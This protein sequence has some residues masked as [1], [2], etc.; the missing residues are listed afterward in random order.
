MSR[1]WIR[2]Q[3]GVL[4]FL[5]AVVTMELWNL[6][7]ARRPVRGRSGCPDI[8][9]SVLVP[10]R[11]EESRIG[12]CMDSLLSQDYP[13][14]EV[15]VLDDESE[16]R[17]LDAARRVAARDDRARAI[18]GGPL[19]EG[20]VGKNWA[21]DQ[22]SRLAGGRLLLFTD[23]DTLHRPDAV[24]TA[25]SELVVNRLGMLTGLPRQV[26]LSP[27]EKL[28]VPMLG[29][30]L[31]C[32]LPLGIAHRSGSPPLGAAVG[33]FMLF[34]REAYAATGGHAGCRD[35]IAE[36]F[37]LARASV[38][39]GLSWRFFDLGGIVECRM[40]R[41]WAECVSGLSKNL[42]P[43]FGCH[44][45]LFAFVWS[46]LAVV[47]LEPVIVLALRAV[48]VRIPRAAAP[49]A[50]L[51]VTLSLVMWTI[52]AAKLGWPLRVAAVYPAIT[53]CS[54]A[55]AFASMVKTLA[56]RTSW[57]GRALARPKIHLL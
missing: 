31:L 25:V 51:E 7:H 36:D 45:A 17:T 24:S 13:E 37:A 9:V 14:L 21:C 15:L 4:L 46:W 48:G 57:S 3:H 43:A 23:A 44:S 26:M 32:F 41:G 35:Q 22:L 5:C 54:V 56:G 8:P 27:G 10:A 1:R 34:E 39:A 38:R 42:F 20:W 40:Y 50:F 6:R 16:D 19:P 52:A 2:H 30:S 28:F 55:V 29:F 18:A 53:G 11:N 12:P 33:Q 47:F 49:Y